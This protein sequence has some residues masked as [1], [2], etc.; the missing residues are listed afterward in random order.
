MT[1]DLEQPPSD[2]SLKEILERVRKAEGPDRDLD[3]RMFS[4]VA[5]AYMRGHHWRDSLFVD[6][7]GKS[8][9]PNAIDW[10]KDGL[11]WYQDVDMPRYSESLDACLALMAEVL[12]GWRW[13]MAMGRSRPGEPLY[14]ASLLSPGRSADEE[15]DVIAEHEVGPLA[16]LD[17]ILSALLSQD[18]SDAST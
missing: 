14:G 7:D 3:W 6:L 18:Q 1:I 4:N 12:P 10:S 11:R 8:A 16:L 15:P 9:G 5:N 2:P 17:C 13:Y